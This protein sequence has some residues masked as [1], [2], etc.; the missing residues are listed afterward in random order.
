VNGWKFLDP[1]G[2]TYYEGK[3]FQY[4]LPRPG[5]KW[6]GVTYAPDPITEDDS[7]DCGPG[8][9]HLMKRPTNPYGPRNGW[10]WYAKAG[11]IIREG[12]DEKFWGTSVQLR[13]VRPAVWH[14]IIRLGWCSGADLSGAD[15]RSAYLR[16]ADLSNARYNDYTI[17]PDGFDYEGATN[18]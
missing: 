15:L 2:S 10:P 3:Q 14:R 17:W 16:G 1:T 18:A 7:K 4:V 9:I 8:R 5:E 11:G 13:M 12:S 6:G